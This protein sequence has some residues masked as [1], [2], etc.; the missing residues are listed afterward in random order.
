MGEEP[1]RGR[2]T[3]RTGSKLVPSKPRISRWLLAAVGLA[4]VLGLVAAAYFLL[5]PRVASVAVLP[6]QN[7]TGDPEMA[8]LT[9]GITESLI[10]DLSRIPTLRVIA[11]GS[12][13]EVRRSQSRSAGSRPPT[14][15]H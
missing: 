1:H 14:G 7:R 12:V 9:E 3:I 6:F 13:L 11:R 8:Y 2:S 5:Q 4:V 15:C 10:N